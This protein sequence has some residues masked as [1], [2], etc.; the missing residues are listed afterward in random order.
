M[1][2]SAKK[3]QSL[4]RALGL[5][6]VAPALETNAAESNDEW[7]NFETVFMTEVLALK[8]TKRPSGAT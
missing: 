3:A 7:A 1:R 4:A 6:S 5:T 2:S 8:L